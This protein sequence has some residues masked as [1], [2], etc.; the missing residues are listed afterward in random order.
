[1][2]F[3]WKKYGYMIIKHE[4]EKKRERELEFGLP[5]VVAQDVKETDLRRS[6]RIIRAQ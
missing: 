2:L 3:R 5:A 1:M 4:I 6:V